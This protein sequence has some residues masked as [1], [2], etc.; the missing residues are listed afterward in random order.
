M[1]YD[2]GLEQLEY[3]MYWH[4]VEMSHHHMKKR[5]QMTPGI[6]IPDPYLFPP[7]KHTAAHVVAETWGYWQH[8]AKDEAWALYKKLWGF[9]NDASNPTPTGGDGSDGTVEDPGGTM[10]PANDDKMPHWWGKLTDG[11]RKGLTL[12]GGHR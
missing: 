4:Q 9:Q 3:A 5:E 8:M 2:D 10:D 6:H 11:E 12:A 1:S 7:C